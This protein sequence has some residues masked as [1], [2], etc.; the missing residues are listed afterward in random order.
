VIDTVV[1][2]GGSLERAGLLEP[3]LPVLAEA[4]RDGRGLLVVPGG[5]RFAD[6]VREACARRDP[7][8]DAAHWAAVLAM[9]Q[10]AHVIV[11][12]APE[13]A[14][15]TGAEAAREAVAAGRLP[16]L[17]PYAWLRAEDPLPHTW[18]VTG[19]SI[20]AWVAARVG[21]GTLL[22]VKSVAAPR[23]AVED[24]ARRGIVDAYLP[25]ALDLAI[26]WHVVDGGDLRHLQMAI[27]SRVDRSDSPA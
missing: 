26:S 24:L 10:L 16:V 18:D 12:Q 6:A 17:A 20:A 21:A 11:G 13:A 1:K 14:L 3:I 15:V 4:V 27:G 8:T 2:L 5:G 19:D 25:S 9:D 23:A 7:G 22:L